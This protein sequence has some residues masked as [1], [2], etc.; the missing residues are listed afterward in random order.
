ML[1]HLAY[2]F[3]VI[4]IFR[5]R[6]FVEISRLN[7]ILLQIRQT[8]LILPPCPS[9]SSALGSSVLDLVEGTE[10]I[11]SCAKVKGEVGVTLLVVSLSH[12]SPVKL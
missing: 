5:P 4:L 8:I 11:L 9:F 7:V 3:K 2:I 1:A 6:V 10:V 12:H